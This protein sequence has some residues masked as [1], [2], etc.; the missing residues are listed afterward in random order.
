MSVVVLVWISAVSPS[1]GSPYP[2][3]LAQ[4]ESCSRNSLARGEHPRFPVS[5]SQI[6]TVS[7]CGIFLF[8]LG[9]V[10]D[11]GCLGVMLSQVR[12]RSQ[13]REACRGNPGSRDPSKRR[14]NSTTHPSLVGSTPR[15]GY[16]SCA[17]FLPPQK[18]S[19]R[20]L[21]PCTSHTSQYI[22]AERS[23]PIWT[24]RVYFLGGDKT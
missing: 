11:L 6:S 18:P 5:I 12:C 13:P 2:S 17:I 16:A 8:L 22:Y 15:K 4:G 24:P 9:G 21:V 23:A 20:H 19:D 14:K 7:R 1:T 10:C 3:R